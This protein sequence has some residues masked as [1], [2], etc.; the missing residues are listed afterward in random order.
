[1]TCL[2]CPRRTRSLQLLSRLLKNG[3]KR[4]LEVWRNSGEFGGETVG[5]AYV[6][7]VKKASGKLYWYLAEKEMVGGKRAERIIRKL[8][9]EE[10][11]TM[12][13]SGISGTQIKALAENP[14]SPSTGPL[15]TSGDEENEETRET[16]GQAPTPMVETPSLTH[17]SQES[18]HSMES[19][20]YYEVVE[21]G[22]GYYALNPRKTNLKRGYV[23]VAESGVF[24][25]GCPEWTCEHVKYMRER[26]SKISLR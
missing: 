14:S 15:G 16:R 13:G 4:L 5:R 26:L 23:L 3:A 8:S 25:G 9:E 10:A 18:D 1:M 21:K 19:K 12:L 22:G 17:T 24:C 6:K 20:N 11:E 7:S 2:Y